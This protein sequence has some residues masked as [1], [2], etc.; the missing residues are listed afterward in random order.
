M[1]RISLE[2]TPPKPGSITITITIT[3]I[4]ILIYY[5]SIAHMY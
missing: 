1:H 3:I 4:S 5:S 2:S